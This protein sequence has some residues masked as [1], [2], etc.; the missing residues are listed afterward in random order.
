MSDFVKKLNTFSKGSAGLC[1]K[2]SITQNQIQTI[3]D[4]RKKS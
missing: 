1:L 2:G 4:T 3:D